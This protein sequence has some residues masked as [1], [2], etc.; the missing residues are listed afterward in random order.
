VGVAL[1]EPVAGL[2]YYCGEIQALDDRGVRVTGF[3]WL[4]GLFTQ[5]DVWFPWT[6]VLGMT[7]VATSDH[8]M[9]EWADKAGGAQRRHNGDRLD[10]QGPDETR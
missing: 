2:R 9:H 5:F 6:N 1:A 10:D 3:D 7:E 4:V 8:S